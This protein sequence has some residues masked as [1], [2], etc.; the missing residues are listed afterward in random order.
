MLW[1]TNIVRQFST[2][3]AKHS[4][5]WTLSITYKSPSNKFCSLLLWVI[6]SIVV[7]TF[8]GNSN[9]KPPHS[10][11]NLPKNPKNHSRFAW[12]RTERQTTC[13]RDVGES[14]KSASAPE[15][16]IAP[17]SL[18]GGGGGG[19]TLMFDSRDAVAGSF[20]GADVR[21]SA[22]RTTPG[23]AHELREGDPWNRARGEERGFPR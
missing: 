5:Y 20:P 13:Q 12:A 1:T 10:L 21:F 23:A 22:W 4:L 7:Q 2:S 18:G 11:R 17:G 8:V 6:R 3:F 19:G 16:E 14:G 9:S 15:S